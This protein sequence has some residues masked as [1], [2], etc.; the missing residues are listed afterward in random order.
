MNKLVFVFLFII[1]FM[2]F[3]QDYERINV[4]ET[5]CEGDT[6]EFSPTIVICQQ[7]KV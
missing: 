2:V 3:S 7:K 4:S 6:H 5:V 1:P